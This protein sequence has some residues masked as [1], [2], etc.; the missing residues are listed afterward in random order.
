MATRQ[1]PAGP[2]TNTIY[3]LKV[4]LWGSKP[5]IWRRIQTPG[6]T[7]LADLHRIIQAAMGWEAHHLHQFS[8]GD[9]VYGAPEP[10]KDDQAFEMRDERR[11]RL[12][13]VAP[14]EGS[15]FTYQYDFGDGWDHNIT[16][17]KILEPEP[18]ARYPRCLAGR[19]ACPPEDSGGIQ[20]Y[21][22]LIETLKT[23]DNPEYAEM[24][25]WVGDDF[26]PETFSLDDTNADLE[27][28]RG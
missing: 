22:D 18:G 28:L 2:A 12:D 20:G 4:T 25:E 3:Q 21:V 8:A 13:Q 15:K 24:R 6:S 26:N 17:E 1:A 5:P 14:A 7:S 10:A 11:A 9:T 19:R 16:V 27:A 23:P